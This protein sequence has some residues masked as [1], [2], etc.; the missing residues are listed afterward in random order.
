MFA[1]GQLIGV[2]LVISSPAAITALVIATAF[3][4]HR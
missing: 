4:T 1:G 2:R 3:D